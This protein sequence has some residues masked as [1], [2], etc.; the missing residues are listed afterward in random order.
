MNNV[1]YQH[2]LKDMSGLRSGSPEIRLPPFR[3][4]RFSLLSHAVFLLTSK[5][6]QALTRFRRFAGDLLLHKCLTVAR[7]DDFS[8]GLSGYQ[9]DA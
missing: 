8:G 5:E 9:A 1:Y 2:F 3:V 4:L 7:Q 6:D